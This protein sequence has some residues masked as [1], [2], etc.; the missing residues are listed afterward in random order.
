M[1]SHRQAGAGEGM[2][3][4]DV[5]GQAQHFADL[6]HFV[7]EQLAQ[8]L[9]QLEAQFLGQ[10]ADVVV[11][12]DV[13]GRAG[14]AMAGFDHVGVERALGQELAR[15]GS[16]A[17]SRLKASMNSRPMILRFCCGSVTPVSAVE[18]LLAGVVDAQVDLEMIAEGRFHQLPLVLSQQAVVH[19][20]ADELIAD[21][22]VQQGRHDG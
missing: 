10:A 5:L 14:I 11:Q 17:A 4:D 22:F 2:P 6:A 13:G 1:H 21:G 20:D 12:L 18:E 15:R 3:P 19:E 9:D 7:L 8:R 16:T